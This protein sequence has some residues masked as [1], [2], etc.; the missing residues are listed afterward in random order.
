MEPQYS[1]QSLL[2]SLLFAFN[3]PSSESPKHIRFKG[4]RKGKDAYLVITIILIQY[5]H[6]R[7]L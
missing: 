7:D 4:K 1:F 3:L 5:A 6:L 2:R